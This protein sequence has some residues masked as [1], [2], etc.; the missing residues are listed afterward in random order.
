MDLELP[1][2]GDGGFFLACEDFGGMFNDSFPTC[3]FFVK[4]EISSR[5]L[6]FLF[7]FGHDRSTVVQETEMTG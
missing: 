3:I 6:H 2:G 1:C 7:F 5:T 4:V